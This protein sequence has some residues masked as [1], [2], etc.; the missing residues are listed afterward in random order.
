MDTC[1]YLLLQPYSAQIAQS[2]QPPTH[3][4]VPQSVNPAF[5]SNRQSPYQLQFAQQQ[6]LLQQLTQ[7][8]QPP[9]TQRPILQQQPVLSQ[10]VIANGP[11]LAIVPNPQINP[12]PINS[13]QMQQQQKQLQ[14][15]QQQ[16]QQ[17]HHQ[18]QLQQLQQL[19]QQRQ[20]M[21]HQ[22]LQQPEQQLQNQLMQ[23]QPMSKS[24]GHEQRLREVENQLRLQQEQ[25]RQQQLQL[26][27][28]QERRKLLLG[29]ILTPLVNCK[30][31]WNKLI[32][33]GV[34]LLDMVDNKS[35]QE[36][37]FNHLIRHGQGELAKM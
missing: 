7:H 16:Q 12:V 20:Q 9:G 2:M 25:H 27:I 22:L 3:Q 37:W 33:R 24:F 13:P 28:L 34:N 35:Q 29:H 31:E 1:I 18:Q 26:A 8:S 30:P 6:A 19:Q 4:I 23:L 21:N 17:H 36:E 11:F 5:F 32:P 10:Q 14:L 15:Q